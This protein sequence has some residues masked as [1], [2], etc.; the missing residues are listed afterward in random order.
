MSLVSLLLPIVSQ[1]IAGPGL[2]VIFA[3]FSP[4]GRPLLKD[5]DRSD[6]IHMLVDPLKGEFSVNR[7]EI[8]F[9]VRFLYREKRNVSKITFIILPKKKKSTHSVQSSLI[10]LR[11][12]KRNTVQK[13]SR[14]S[15]RPLVSP[16]YPVTTSTL[17]QNYQQMCHCGIF[18]HFYCTASTNVNFS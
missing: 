5:V 13:C 9:S 3:L 7:D 12:I 2:D 11:L 15:S 16:G 8:D 10:E 6:G 1:V 4:S 18:T 14:C 17:P